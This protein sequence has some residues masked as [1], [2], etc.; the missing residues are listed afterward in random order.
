[1]SDVTMQ[2]RAATLARATEAMLRAL[3]G[4]DVVLRC[5]VAPAGNAGNA[6][7][8]IEGPVTED[9]TV[10]P[11]VARS[12]VGASAPGVRLEFLFAPDSLARYLADRGESA[13]DFF[14]SALGIVHGQA[15]LHIESMTAESFAKVPYLYRV[16]ASTQQ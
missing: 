4:S 14:S 6:E 11:V 5:P 2:S 8:G 7:L 13:E 3:G 10:T 12:V 1:M 15:L 9:V 16:I